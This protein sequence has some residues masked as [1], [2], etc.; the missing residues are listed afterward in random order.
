MRRFDYRFLKYSEIPASVFSRAIGIARLRERTEFRR[1]RNPDVFRELESSA[2]FMSVRDS[3][4]IEGIATS[5]SR[6]SSLM[7]RSVEPVGHDEVEIAGYR[8]ALELIH[9]NYDDL[10]LNENTIRNLHRMISYGDGGEYKKRDN[11]IMEVDEDGNRHV[12]FIPTPAKETPEAMEQLVLSYIHGRQEGVEPLLLIPC[13]ILDFL[14]I[15][16]F[17]DGNGR[18]SRLLTLL[19]LYQEGYDV[20]RYMSFE[21]RIS[22]TKDGYY[23][24]LSRSSQGWS[25]GR[26]DYFPFI[27]YYLDTLSSCY[28][29]LDRCF[30]TLS[31]KKATKK[32]RIEAAVMN[33]LAPISKREIMS[34]LP[35]VSEDTVEACL[36]RMIVDGRIEKIGGNRNARYRPALHDRKHQEQ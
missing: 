7:D 33:S 16:P 36:H 19:L 12:H 23:H 4:A 13:F 25:E 17:P 3:N 34:L 27:A 29:G 8:D 21:E 30:A 32:N 28:I 31:G 24:A 26:N 15:H 18:V 11:V 35:D 2:R 6:L 20:G 10:Q 9:N 14:S 5:D 1:S 22:C